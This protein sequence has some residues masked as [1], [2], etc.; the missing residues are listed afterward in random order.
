MSGI[1]SKLSKILGFLLKTNSY[2][3]KFARFRLFNILY[4]KVAND[5]Y[6]GYI[7]PKLVRCLVKTVDKDFIL[8]STCNDW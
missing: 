4:T 5:K 3:L 1:V 8:C 7:C 2:E 6:F